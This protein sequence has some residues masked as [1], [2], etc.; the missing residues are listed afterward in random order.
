MKLKYLTLLVITFC[1]VWVQS[2]IGQDSTN[3]A[4]FMKIGFGARAIALGS[5]FV[6]VAD[7]ASAG[8]WNPAG[9]AQLSGFSISLADR[10]PSLDMD[11]A[12]FALASPIPKLGFLGLS[13]IYFGC[14][15]IPMY[16]NNGLNT[17][18]L[19]DREMAVILSYAYKLNQLSLGANAKYI[20]QG[21]SSTNEDNIPAYDGMGADLSVLYRMYKS[22]MVG[23]AFHSKYK[24]NGDNG[25]SDIS[26]FDVRAGIYYKASVGRDNSLNFML[27][28]DQTKSYPLKLHFG[29]ELAL[30]DTL[31]LRAGLDDFYAETR[32]ANIDYLD[33]I[34]HS[35]KPTFGLGF[36]W[37]MSKP[38][39][40][41]QAKQN[42][43]MFDYAISIEKL[44]LRN[45]FTL[46]Y[47]F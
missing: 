23:A 15:E 7:D 46:S 30:Y 19:T 11:Y 21:M 32:N 14:G 10:V 13:V 9:L 22:L 17:G 1:V 2:S 28:L 25:I 18:T 35:V 6:A 31:M 36:K 24:I 34:K 47:Q 12:S 43:L 4:P 3:A 41:P 5:A 37:K 33:L 27:D 44:G 29:T 38:G 42:A 26:P 20:Y 16:D 8:Y 40:L 45:F 39:S